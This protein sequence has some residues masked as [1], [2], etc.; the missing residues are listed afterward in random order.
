MITKKKNKNECVLRVILKVKSRKS[1]SIIV[2][3][4]ISKKKKLVHFVFDEPLV[5]SNFFHDIIELVS[6]L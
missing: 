6:L 4:F 1:F 5:S 2:D 3:I